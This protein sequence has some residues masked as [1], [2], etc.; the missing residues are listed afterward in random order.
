MTIDR[1][2]M[3]LDNDHEDDTYFEIPGDAAGEL[4]ADIRKLLTLNE[5]FKIALQ[6]IDRME[7]MHPSDI[8]GVARQALTAMMMEKQDD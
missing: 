6:K 5:N 3:L 8:V 4:A 7:N 1:W 2:L